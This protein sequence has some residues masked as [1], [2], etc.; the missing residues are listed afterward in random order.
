MI[1]DRVTL[2]QPVV[3]AKTG[4]IEANRGFSFWDLV[5]IVNPLQHVPIIGTCYRSVTGDEIDAPARL[6]GGGLFG[7]VLGALSGLVNI[8]VEAV[9]GKDVGEHV[10]SLVAGLSDGQR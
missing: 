6:I 2:S 1:Q 5:D 9:T 8:A 3:P 10:L 4:P 7:G